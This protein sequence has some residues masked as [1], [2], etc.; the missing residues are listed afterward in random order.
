MAIPHDNRFMHTKICSGSAFPAIKDVLWHNGI[1]STDK[2]PLRNSR[3]FR[4]D[5]GRIYGIF[6]WTDIMDSDESG[7]IR[8]PHNR[9]NGQDIM[10]PR[11]NQHRDRRAAGIADQIEARHIIIFS[12]AV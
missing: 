8:V 6:Q 2:M 5:T 7:I 9:T 12:D 1:F 10:P 4:S 11:C 3:Y